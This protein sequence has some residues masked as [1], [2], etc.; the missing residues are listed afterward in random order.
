M[1][2]DWKKCRLQA[3]NM[4]TIRA[5]TAETPTATKALSQPDLH[6]PLRSILAR[7]LKVTL[8]VLLTAACL[9]FVPTAQVQ[10]AE[11][12]EGTDDYTKLFGMQQW[13]GSPGQIAG[14]TLRCAS[15]LS[16]GHYVLIESGWNS[17]AEFTA[18]KPVSLLHD[19]TTTA[20]AT[21]PTISSVKEKAFHNSWLSIYISKTKDPK[22][23]ALGGTYNQIWQTP[24]S[25]TYDVNVSRKGII[26]SNRNISSPGT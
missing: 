10:E 7:V 9:P 5:S 18:L 1:R 11:A 25:Q 22:S 16:N 17:S 6:P 14:K 3:D 24:S 13:Y 4:S 20:T 26:Q 2:E 19:W 15:T 21:I 12:L 23:D 8:A